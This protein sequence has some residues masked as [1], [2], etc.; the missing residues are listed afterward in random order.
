MWLQTGAEVTK[1]LTPGEQKTHQLFCP[2]VLLGELVF[3]STSSHTE[4]QLGKQSLSQ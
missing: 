4:C 3:T 2:P 1:S